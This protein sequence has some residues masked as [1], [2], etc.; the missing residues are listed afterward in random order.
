M[1]RS[2]LSGATVGTAASTDQAVCQVWNPS[3]APTIWV[4]EIH[5]F[6]L[7]AGGADILKIRRSSARGTSAS[8]VTS[9]LEND[10]DSLIAPPSVWILDLDFSVEPTADGDFLYSLVAPASIGVGAM[11]VFEE[12]IKVKPATALTVI[13]GLASFPVAWASAVVLE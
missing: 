6:K 1:M 8:S 13:S 5:I 11:W 9:G 2:A 10:H 3:G 4:R 12:P 7:T